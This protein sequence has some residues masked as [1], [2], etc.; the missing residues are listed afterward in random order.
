VGS[1]LLCTALGV[2]WLILFVRII[3]SWTTMFWSPPS[4]L[5]PLVRVIYDLTEPVMGLFR[6]FIP[7]MGGIDLSPIFI[8][9]ALSIV[10]RSIGC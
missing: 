5:T 8:F 3:L 4:S 10:R 6:R 7:P 1:E 9:I 2:Y